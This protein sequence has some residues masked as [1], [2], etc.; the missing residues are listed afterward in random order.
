MESASPTELE[1]AQLIVETLNL[2][3]VT[4]EEIESE[5]PLFRDGLGLDSID[6][7]ELSLGIKQKYGIQLKAD[8]ENL[9][10]IF[11]SLSKLTQ[12]I[13]DNR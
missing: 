13:V 1:V 3:D 4:A 11:S 10:E 7:L 12:Y 2:E 5:A 6:A 8:D 9:T